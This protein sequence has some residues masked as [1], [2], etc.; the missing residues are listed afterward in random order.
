[1]VFDSLVVAISSLDLLPHLGVAHLLND[2]RTTCRDGRE[3]ETNPALSGQSEDFV[4]CQDYGKETLLEYRVRT[5]F[6]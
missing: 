1:M 5:T 4:I 6:E 3:T 2:I